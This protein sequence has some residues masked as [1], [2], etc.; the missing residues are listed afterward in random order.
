MRRIESS[1]SCSGSGLLLVVVVDL[2]MM[3]GIETDTS[4]LTEQSDQA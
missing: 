4:N 2:E 3:A 1:V